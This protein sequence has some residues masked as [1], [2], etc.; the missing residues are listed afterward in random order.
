M[1]HLIEHVAAR[2]PDA[3]ASIRRSI[4]LKYARWMLRKHLTTEMQRK[5]VIL[6]QQYN[7]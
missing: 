2:S 7:K 6:E 3:M 4:T 5:I 1:Y